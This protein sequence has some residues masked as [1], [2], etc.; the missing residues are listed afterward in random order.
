MLTQATHWLEIVAIALDVILLGRLLLLR[1]YRLYVFITLACVLAVFFDAV[2]LWLDADLKSAG[3]VFIY[4]RFLYAFLFPLI[5]WDVFEEVKAQVA[6]LRRLA[7]IRL[8]SGLVFACLFG[9][10]VTAFTDTADA[11]G[12]PSSDSSPLTTLGLIFWAGSS[13][14]TLAFLWTL[15]RQT[16]AQK[17]DLPNNTYVWMLFWELSLLYEVFYCFW[18]L[19]Y[20]LLKSTAP[21]VEL[22]FFVYGIAITA[23]CVF[24][25]RAVP[26]SVPS[27]PANAGL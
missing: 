2:V 14:A 11:S 23:W 25:L 15:H 16:R 24:K 20:S 10:I 27:A 22:L 6:K 12:T 9:F 1:L 13:T 4:S 8:V 19:S 7:I 3:M 26:A 18:L 17:I 21:Y 5:A